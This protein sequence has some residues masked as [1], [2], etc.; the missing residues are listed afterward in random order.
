MEFKVKAKGSWKSEKDICSF[1]VSGNKKKYQ[2]CSVV[3]CNSKAKEDS[4]GQP[5]T[6]KHLDFA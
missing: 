1:S 4:I 6:R 5:F 3:K 2:V